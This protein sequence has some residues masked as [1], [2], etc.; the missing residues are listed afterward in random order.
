MCLLFFCRQDDLFCLML[1]IRV[2]SFFL[3]HNIWR[4]RV[5]QR[6]TLGKLRVTFVVVTRDIF[7]SLP[8][9]SQ[10]ITLYQNHKKS[11]SALLIN[12]LTG[13][14]FEPLATLEIWTQQLLLA[15]LQGRTCCTVAKGIVFYAGI[16]LFFDFGPPYQTI[17]LI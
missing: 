15:P 16:A 12:V 8:V 14:F 17:N 7:L 1:I 10:K 9:G 4:R 6:F 3:L 13:N 2:Y 11:T 5:A